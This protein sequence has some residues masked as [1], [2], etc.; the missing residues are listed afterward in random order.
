MIHQRQSGGTARRSRPSQHFTLE[1]Q[2]LCFAIIATIALIS[3]AI[4]HTGYY[5]VDSFHN[6][7]GGSG[8][9]NIPRQQ[10]REISN[11][12][13]RE[14]NIIVT[15]TSNATALQENDIDTI[16][17]LSSNTE[18]RIIPEV[19]R[20]D[21]SKSSPSSDVIYSTSPFFTPVDEQHLHKG[22]V[23]RELS[24]RILSRN[25]AQSN[26]IIVS[27]N[28]DKVQVIENNNAKV[29]VDEVV[30][31]Y[32]P[33]KAAIEQG[34]TTHLLP[35]STWHNSTTI[36]G[37]VLLAYFTTQNIDSTIQNE[38]PISI[39][40]ILSSSSSA[41][42]WLR[43][44]T[45]TYIV[46]PIHAKASI[47]LSSIIGHVYEY[48]MDYIVDK[49]IKIVGLTAASTLLDSNYKLQ[50]LSSSHYFDPI[51]INDATTKE[52]Y[53]Y[54]PNALFQ[55]VKAL[56]RFLYTRVTQVLQMEVNH[57]RQQHLNAQSNTI[58][59]TKQLIE[60][61]FHSLLFATQG[62]DL[63]I[64]SRS[65]YTD[66]SNHKECKDA[67]TGIRKKRCDP[68]LNARALNDTIFL[69]CPER[70]NEIDVQFVKSS[71]ISQLR[72]GGTQPQL[73]ER[74]RKRRVNLERTP[75]EK[76]Q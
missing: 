11:T 73:V 47:P 65:S 56:H 69:T 21:G 22:R 51:S 42:S 39:D 28:F 18:R 7:V 72:I 61:E 40:D 32:Y 9:D 49:T 76:K 5:T 41:T 63:A 27:S 33:A 64:P 68:K 19:T 58:N 2:F 16:L 37:W 36:G 45:V 1:R 48:D 60:V 13:R 54:G 70:H 59:D 57:L 34:H 14:Y 15:D 10:P 67:N 12:L 17:G 26:V 66:V 43:Q 3:Y 20:D 30:Q 55:S 31:Q 44:T 62:L 6:N 23:V 25:I 35:S 46:F 75:L 38:S 74:V 29:D 50:L 4:I 71:D 8:L 53:K 52:V 24:H